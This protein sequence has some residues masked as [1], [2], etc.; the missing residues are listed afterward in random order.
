M[1]IPKLPAAWAALALLLAGCGST[2]PPAAPPADPAFYVVIPETGGLTAFGTQIRKGVEAALAA[3]NEGRSGAGV[4]RAE[5]IDDGCDTQKASDV[6][7]TL[8]QKKPRV[9]L[10]HVCSGGTLPASVIYS[11]VQTLMITAA[12]SNVA[13]TE[14]GLPNVFR[15]AMRADVYADG[16]ARLIAER[17]AQKRFAI[18]HE[19]EVSGRGH[20]E[21]V[22]RLLAQRG[23]QP[24]FTTAIA[25]VEDAPAIA[26]RL[27]DERID[28]VFYGGHFPEQLGALLKAARGNGFQGQFVSND[29]ASNA[30]LWAESGGAA[31]GLL[32]AFGADFRNLPEAAGAVARIRKGGFEPDGF[33]MNAYAATE[34]VVQGLRGSAASGPDLYNHFR[35]RSFSTAIGQVRFDAKGDVSEP[36]V[37]IYR[38]NAGTA[39]AEKN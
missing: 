21:Q 3:A 35:S 15:V 22:T 24:L 18:V 26:R 27:A 8:A 10:G 39:V 2:P 19:S 29:G 32:Y 30:K 28:V 7:R 38:W 36:R 12:S 16:A 20:A 25:K 23:I 4:L 11:D 13:F 14:R 31:Q 6:A 1:R 17:Y 5:F 9:V 37:A 33:T 34:I